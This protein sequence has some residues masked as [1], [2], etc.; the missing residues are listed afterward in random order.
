[1]MMREIRAEVE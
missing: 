1:M